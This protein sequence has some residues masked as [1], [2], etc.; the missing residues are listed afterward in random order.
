MASLKRTSELSALT[1]PSTSTVTRPPSL[2]NTQLVGSGM[3]LR[4][5]HRCRARSDGTLG[6]PWRA[7]YSGLAQMICVRSMILTAT[8]EESG[9]F[10][11]RIAISTFSATRSTARFVT[12]KSIVMPR[13]A[14]QK[15]RQ[16]RS[17]M[18]PDHHRRRMHAQ[19]AARRRARRSDLR[20]R[21][22]DRRKDLA[23]ALEIGRAFRR[24]RQLPRGP[25]EEAHTEA[26]LQPRDRASTPPM[27]KARHPGPPRRSC[28]VR[29]PARIRSSHWLSWSLVKSIHECSALIADYPAGC[30]GARSTDGSVARMQ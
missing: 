10:P 13:I 22:L 2:L 5:R 16:R 28:R 9:S 21:G 25:V 14:R 4:I 7:R 17:E 12:R 18:I 23:R 11:V 27:A 8:S 3:P 20:F 26:L 29:P 24:Q 15:F 19:M 30:K 1:A 6:R